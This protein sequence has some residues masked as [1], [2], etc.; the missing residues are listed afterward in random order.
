VDACYNVTC[1][2]GQYCVPEDSGQCHPIGA[3]CYIDGCPAGEVCEAYE[4]VADPCGGVECEEGE[5]CNDDT[6]ISVCQVA[7]MG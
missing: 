6:D 7:R 4:C 1:A 2:E 3:N 5:Y